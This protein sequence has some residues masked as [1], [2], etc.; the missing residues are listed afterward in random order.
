MPNVVVGGWNVLDA[1]GCRALSSLRVS[2]I[3]NPRP[4]FLPTLIM[5]TSNSDCVCVCSRYFLL[6]TFFAFKYLPA[7][8]VPFLI[9]YTVYRSETSAN[10]NLC[11]RS[12]QYRKACIDP[13]S[14][15]RNISK[16]ILIVFAPLLLIFSALVVFWEYVYICYQYVYICPISLIYK[17]DGFR[18]LWSQDFNNLTG[19]S[20][21]KIYR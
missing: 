10:N 21:P 12:P 2:I 20:V 8:R 19:S 16:T 5:K 18:M 1:L 13:Y 3:A 17:L 9:S 7:Q 11:F 15:P 4:T 6:N 14:A